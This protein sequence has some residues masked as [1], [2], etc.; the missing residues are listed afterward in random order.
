MITTITKKRVPPGLLG[1]VGG[2]RVIIFGLFSVGKLN[3]QKTL[4]LKVKSGDG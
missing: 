1:G 2:P 4:T 3:L